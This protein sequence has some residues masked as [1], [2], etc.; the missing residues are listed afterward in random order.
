MLLSRKGSVMTGL[1]RVEEAGIK[2]PKS[3]RARKI[4]AAGS[5][6]REGSLEERQMGLDGMPHET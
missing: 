3:F 1:K 5:Q 2:E 4:P 6:I